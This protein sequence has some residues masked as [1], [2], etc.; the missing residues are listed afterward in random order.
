MTDVT[1][2]RTVGIP[3]T[4]HDRALEFS[5]GPDERLP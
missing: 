2:V 1:G 5:V 4:D 3:G